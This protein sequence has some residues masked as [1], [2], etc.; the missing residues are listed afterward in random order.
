LELALP[1]RQRRV[2]DAEEFHAWVSDD[3]VSSI[4][5]RCRLDVAFMPDL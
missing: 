4:I 5:L 1:L 2:G 3:S